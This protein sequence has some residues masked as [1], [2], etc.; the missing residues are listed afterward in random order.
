M[1]TG[2]IKIYFLC[3]IPLMG[4]AQKGRPDKKD[5]T[6]SEKDLQTEAVFVEGMKYFIAEDY[7]N[8][9][10]N[11]KVIVDK[12]GENA[13]AFFMLSRI[14]NLQN[15]LDKATSYAEKAQSIDKE[16]VFYQKQYGELLVKSKRY[17]EAVEVFRKIEK[18]HPGDIENY[19]ALADAY[20]V[21]NKSSEAI[22]VFDDLERTIGVNE[23]IT[24]QKQLIFLNQN[25]VDAALKEGDKLMKSEPLEPEFLIQ[26][27]QI[28]MA[29]NRLNEAID[30]LTEN[31]KHNPAIGEANVLLSEIYRKKGD[32]AKSNEQLQKAFANKSLTAD[33]KLKILGNYILSIDERKE[34]IDY[35]QLLSLT[36]SV[37]QQ[38]P[39]E[40]KAYV[41]LAD[42]LVKKGEPEKAREAYLQAVKYDSSIFEVWL[43]IIELDSKLNQMKE[44][45]K[46]SEKA[47]EYFPN[48]AFLW[49]QNGMGNYVLKNYEDAVASLQEAGRLASGNPDLKNHVNALLG[50]AWNELKQYT[51]SDAAYETVLKD[52]PDFEYVLN[53]YSYFLAL[54]K[55]KLDRAKELSTTL[56]SK[57][58]NNASYLDTHAWVLYQQNDYQ[59]AKKIIEQALTI[60]PNSS[61]AVYDHYGDVLYKLGDKAR[62][63]EQ[64]K[65]ALSKSPEN[66]T[67]GK[68][69]TTGEL[70]E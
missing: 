10:K 24:R 30:L 32:I 67:I 2:I 11:F 61:A 56:I 21:Q 51:K 45:V 9:G 13:G 26:Q 16:N 23:E 53:N 25:K 66:Q 69:I 55:Q 44:L 70:I 19:L 63:I 41:F 29:N 64:W 46:H 4:M 18:M 36:E 68:K 15:N 40:A 37:I 28:M 57:Y 8:A 62:A 20:M 7:A 47:L 49:H 59:N 22:K 39:Q 3:F 52:A 42:I 17:K 31:L 5:G 1:K 6:V 43:A 35:N 54:R 14:E 58:P 34:P 33:I 60:N 48:Q 65:K 38:A 50:D 27:A 12:S